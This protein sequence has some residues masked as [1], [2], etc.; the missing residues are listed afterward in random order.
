M[1]GYLIN[2]NV[3]GYPVIQKFGTRF[4]FFYDILA[5]YYNE[6]FKLI[7]FATNG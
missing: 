6:F 2:I 4:L 3:D 5:G 7:F 1:L